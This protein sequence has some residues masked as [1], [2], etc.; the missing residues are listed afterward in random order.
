MMRTGCG[1]GR[2]DRLGGTVIISSL[3]NFDTVKRLRKQIFLELQI[4]DVFET[5]P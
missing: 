1:D 4:R 5:C 2:L 3:K